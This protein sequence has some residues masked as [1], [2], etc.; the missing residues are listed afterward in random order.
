MLHHPPQ[1]HTQQRAFSPFTHTNTKSNRKRTQR[2]HELTTMKQALLLLTVWSLL[3]G[4]SSDTTTSI[5]AETKEQESSSYGIDV[6]FPIHHRVSTNYPDL[7]HNMD[8]SLPVP[9]AL[10]DLP[11][12]TLG[13][14]HSFYLKHLNGCRQSVTSSEYAGQCD[15]VEFHRMLMNR[16]QT[17]SMINYTET[18]FQKVQAP[19]HLTKLVAEFW[20]KNR[21]IQKD[22]NWGLGN[23]YF[24]H[25]DN[26]SRVVSVDDTGL[27]GSG[28]KLKEEVWSAL[29]AVMEEW[30]QQEL[31]PSSLYGIRVY[32]EGSVMMPQ[33]VLR[34]LPAIRL[35]LYSDSF[36][37]THICFQ[38]L[39][40]CRSTATGGLRYSQR[41]ARRRRRLAYRNL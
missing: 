7:P 12:Q 28:A 15:R 4:G 20:Q 27:R 23:S 13:P 34:T 1:I 40:Q 30:T 8:P 38:F 16:R 36:R 18:G 29:S 25:W 19:E 33:Y 14:R 6:S 3:Q 2:Y 24:N 26:P 10:K 39:F 9:P 31:Q 5:D 41:C 35:V 32:G 21:L 22:E 37:L 17:Q 11:I